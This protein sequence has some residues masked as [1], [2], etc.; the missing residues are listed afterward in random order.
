MLKSAPSRL[1]MLKA[2]KEEGTLL[3]LPLMSF[4]LQRQQ[5]AEWQNQT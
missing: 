4:S 2:M 5:T 1:G 3:L